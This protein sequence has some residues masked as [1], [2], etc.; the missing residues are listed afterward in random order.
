MSR[1]LSSISFPATAC[2]VSSCWKVNTT[3]V[4]GFV[5]ASPTIEEQ[6]AEVLTVLMAG[7][8]GATE[9]VRRWAGLCRRRAASLR[10][11]SGGQLQRAARY[12]HLRDEARL[13]SVWPLTAPLFSQDGMNGF[14]GNSM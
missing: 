9:A 4:I 14:K 11:Q 10:E 7:D 3:T 12:L 1:P 6:F 2:L 5:A 8:I 13:R